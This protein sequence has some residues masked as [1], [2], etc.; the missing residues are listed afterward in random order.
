MYQ[1]DYTPPKVTRKVVTTTKE[2]D[3]EGRV[4]KETVVEET[5]IES[6]RPW[7]T[8]GNGGHIAASGTDQINP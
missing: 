3:A 4:V 6:S 5:T 2:Y 1:Y 7:I 8:Y